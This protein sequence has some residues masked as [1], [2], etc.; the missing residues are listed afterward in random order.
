VGNQ[1]SNNIGKPPS[2]GTSSQEV[3]VQAVSAAFVEMLREV[4]GDASKTP[5]TE[6]H[7]VYV[8]F[9]KALLSAA[10]EVMER[11]HRPSLS[12][13]EG[14][15]LEECQAYCTA[16]SKVFL[17]THWN[18]AK[19]VGEA[20]K[21][22][23][24]GLSNTLFDLLSQEGWVVNRK[25]EFLNAR[26]CNEYFNALEFWGFNRI[27]DRWSVYNGVFFLLSSTDYFWYALSVMPTE[28]SHLEFEYYF[29]GMQD[30]AEKYLKSTGQVKPDEEDDTG[31]LL[32]DLHHDQYVAVCDDEASSDK[33]PVL[34]QPMMT[35]HFP[36]FM[37]NIADSRHLDVV[38]EE[39]PVKLAKR[40]WRSGYSLTYQRRKLTIF[41]DLNWDVNE[42]GQSLWDSCYKDETECIVLSAGLWRYANGKVAP[43]FELADSA[44]YSVHNP[45]AES[46]HETLGGPQ[47]HSRF[48]AH[49]NVCAATFYMLAGGPVPNERTKKLINVRNV[50][51]VY[52]NDIVRIDRHQRVLTCDRT[53]AVVLDDMLTPKGTEI[54]GENEFRIRPGENRWTIGLEGGKAIHLD[55]KY[56]GLQVIAALLKQPDEKF[57]AL[58]LAST[59]PVSPKYLLEEEA[60]SNNDDQSGDKNAEGKGNFNWEPGSSDYELVSIIYRQCLD[61]LEAATDNGN[62]EKMQEASDEIARL[63]QE[64]KTIIKNLDSE[65]A[66]E[67]K[68]GRRPKDKSRLGDSKEQKYFQAQKNNRQAFTRALALI[69]GMEIEAAIQGNERRS[70]KE[71]KTVL[72]TS[73][74]SSEHTPISFF[75]KESIKT[76]D[77]F[78]YVN[79]DVHW[80]TD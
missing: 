36:W 76:K 20:Y 13:R 7:T 64:H 21:R 22:F 72:K 38:K 67:K 19:N 56:A 51:F 42:M 4:E 48:P 16:L 65:I 1:S 35:F 37:E 73:L 52:L 43:G 63:K 74:I 11:L 46:S 18:D 8:S 58:E 59:L 10:C 23:C 12:E 15:Y 30:I 32:H 28:I 9:C 69:A 57:G 14:E 6:E 50:R 24:R 79:T 17:D 80:L 71:K 33:Q 78:R 54:L 2:S 66:R 53:L 40:T 29:R 26:I 55:N 3:D 61:Q 44:D 41:V 5:E 70:R 45:A 68:S 25:H 34:Y 31:E 62:I 60:G 27:R 77:G 39:E 49:V 47:D 75:L